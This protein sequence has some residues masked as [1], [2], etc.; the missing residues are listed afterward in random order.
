MVR[1]SVCHS[2]WVEARQTQA[3]SGCW[4]PS[5]TE[6][7]HRNCLLFSQ[8]LGSRILICALWLQLTLML[9]RVVSVGH[10]D[11]NDMNSVIYTTCV[12][13]FG[14]NAEMRF[15]K[16]MPMNNVSHVHG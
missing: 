5:P 14:H 2:A 10:P 3:D 6:L 7:S 8:R 12:E 15:L 11:L 16:N 1:V 13:T 4:A 9:V